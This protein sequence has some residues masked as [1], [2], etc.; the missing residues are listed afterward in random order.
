M[1]RGLFQIAIFIRSL[2]AITNDTLW[3]VDHSHAAHAP[4]RPR[5]VECDGAN[6]VLSW[7]PPV[8]YEASGNL[9]GYHVEYRVVGA[10]DWITATNHLVRKTSCT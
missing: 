8:S 1:N 6:V 9:V 4:G 2:F 3:S 10:L 5:V 7:D